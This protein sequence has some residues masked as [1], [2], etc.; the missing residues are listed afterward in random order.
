MTKKNIRGNK[1]TP[2]RSHNLEIS[3]PQTPNRQMPRKYAVKTIQKQPQN[4]RKK[5]PTKVHPQHTNKTNVANQDK[6]SILK[7]LIVITGTIFTFGSLGFGYTL[8]Y[9]HKWQ[10]LMVNETDVNNIIQGQE[11]IKQ[12][13]IQELRI[14]N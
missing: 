1:T 8:R 9:A 5:H 7:Y 6:N 12:E 11:V 4:T 14:N 13:I 10:Q 2:L 3:R